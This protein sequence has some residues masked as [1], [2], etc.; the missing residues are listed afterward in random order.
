MR[1]PALRAVLVR[2]LSACSPLALLGATACGT[3]ATSPS[4]VGGGLAVSA[5]IRAAEEDA[6]QERE[7]ALVASQPKQIGAR[8]ILVMH[9]GSKSRPE[10]VR[11]TRD[12]ARARAQEAL[13]KIRGGAAFE[14]VVAEY[15]DEPG[16]KERG[17]DL[18][19]FER[20]VM[21]KGFADVAF[22]LKVGEVSEVVETPFGFH[23]IKRTE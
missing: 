12:E 19:V 13:L 14:D 22:A 6:A 7:R 10:G 16:A 9:D 17:G 23:I 2:A 11:R 20:G 21:V 8:H 3:L 15:S 4:W 18:G 5:P 1:S